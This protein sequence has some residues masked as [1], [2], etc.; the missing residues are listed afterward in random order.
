MEKEFITI[1]YYFIII[2]FYYLIGL[3][4]SIFNIWYYRYSKW[5]TQP[6]TSDAIAAL[7]GVWVW[8]LQLILFVLIRKYIWRKKK[9]QHLKTK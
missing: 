5:K 3:L 4:V 9:P 8:P 2:L 7:L 1:T 6:K